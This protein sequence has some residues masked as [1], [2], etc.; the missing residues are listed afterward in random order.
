MTVASRLQ[1]VD[2][3]SQKVGVLGYLAI[4]AWSV[5]AVMLTPARFL[6]WVAVLSLLIAAVF[7]PRSLRSILR[8]RWLI[9]I[10]ILA[11]PPVFLVGELD[12]SLGSLHYSS[13]GLVA[14][15]Q[16]GIRILVVL[17]AINGLTSSADITSMAGLLERAGL[18]GIGFSV[19]VA[20]NLL[21]SLQQ[22]ALNAWRSLWMRGGL[23]KQRIRALRLMTVTIMASALNRAE[24]I[25]LAAEARAFSPERARA[26]PVKNGKYDKAILILSFL[27][28]LS[29]IWLP[30]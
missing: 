7:Y 14:S 4:F 22:S 28:L 29:L 25:A 3:T 5:F 20:L 6:P 19:G 17:I 18:H 23:R 13:E 8:L 21:P 24:E 9:M 30:R 12:R 11:L 15:M 27:S 1:T 2:K 16:I 26:L 10:I